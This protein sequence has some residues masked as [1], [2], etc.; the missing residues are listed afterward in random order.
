MKGS[1]FTFFAVMLA[2]GLF[3]SFVDAQKVKTNVNKS[4]TAK[5]PTTPVTTTQK[6]S[7]PG[8]VSD[9]TT[10]EI[11]AEINAARNNPQQFIAYLE[12]Y[13][14]YLKG[15]VLD[16]PGAATPLITIEGAVAVDDAISYLKTLGKLPPYTMS[17][18]LSQSA[19]Y[20]LKDLMID[21]SIGH[22][23]RDGSNLTVRLAKFGKV[24]N[25]HAENITYYNKTAREIVLTMIVDDGTQNRNHR[26]NVFSS[27]FKQIG[28]AFGNGKDREILCV[29]VFADSFQDNNG[30]G[31]QQF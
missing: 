27:V 1:I 11:L 10:Q 31:L 22:K 21:S 12:D 7:S 20:Q 26:K 14:K 19:D 16:K 13:K 17:K 25:A 9:A 23:S 8:Y 5:Q 4:I 6:A 2:C 28:L 30:K 3:S 15:K 18:G 24:G 29:A